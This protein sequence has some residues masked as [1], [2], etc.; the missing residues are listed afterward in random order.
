MIDQQFFDVMGSS[1][2]LAH[3]LG[4]PVNPATTAI[5]VLTTGTYH[6]WVRTKDWAPFPK[7]PGKFELQIGSNYRQLFGSSGTPGWRWYDGGLVEISAADST[8]VTLRDLTGFD[9][10]CDAI[11]LSQ[12]LDFIPP[13]DPLQLAVWR[14]SK[15]GLSDVPN[16]AGQFDMVVVGGGMAGTCAA[17]SAAR[18]GVKVALVQN[19]PV[20]GGNNSSEI[21]VHLM[22]RIDKNDA[23]VLGRIVSE[24]DNGDPGNANED[25]KRYGDQ[26]KEQIVRMQPNLS[27]FLNM[28]VYAV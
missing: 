23:P 11:Y 6:V 7:G 24:L 22:G 28:H 5:Q 19:R 8:I 4:D 14:K 26:R 13:E 15:L 3:G 9:G 2:L 20:L 10:R 18:Q 17:I 21:R 25:P 27:L 16:N 12:D 1:Y